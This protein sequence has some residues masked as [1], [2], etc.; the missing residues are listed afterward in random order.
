MPDIL[1]LGFAPDDWR[2]IHSSPRQIRWAV[3]PSDIVSI[4]FLQPT[5]FKRDLRD[6]DIRLEFEQTAADAG[7]VLIEF[8]V[9][10]IQGL[11]AALQIYKFWHPDPQDMRK[12]YIGTLAFP[13]ADFCYI[14]KAQSVE[15]GMTG[16]RE[17]A[18]AVIEGLHTAEPAGEP[19]EVNSAEE[20][21]SL[22]KQGPL[23]AISA[24]SAAYDAQ[25]PEHPL[26]K[27]RGYLRQIAATLR[28]DPALNLAPPY[29]IARPPEG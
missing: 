14:I 7:G 10:G 6:P 26:S 18:V 24:D 21:F 11:E 12:V 17:A 4:D 23:H 1:S 2:Q 5:D 20:L 15:A 29:R 19:I 13:F 28:V 16:L 22:L 9:Q 8:A 3:T 25:F 27:V